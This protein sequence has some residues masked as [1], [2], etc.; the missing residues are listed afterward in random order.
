MTE[1]MTR[2]LN[3]MREHASESSDKKEALYELRR[4]LFKV[5]QDNRRLEME[6]SL[7]KSDEHLKKE[8]KAY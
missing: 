4:E 1:Q 2:E 7:L 8:Q 3:A 6:N 5:Q